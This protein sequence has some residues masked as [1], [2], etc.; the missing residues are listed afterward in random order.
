MLLFAGSVASATVLGAPDLVVLTLTEF[1]EQTRRITRVA[2]VPLLVDADHGYGNALNVMRCVEELETAGVA[3]ITIEDEALPRP[4][5]AGG[6]TAITLDEACGK[7]R[8][9][10]AARTDAA[11]VLLGR[12]ISLRTEGLETCLRRVEA[13]TRTGVDGLYVAGLQ[14]RQEL[15]ALR[16]AT[17]LPMVLGSVPAELQDADFLAEH[18]VRIRLLGHAPFQAAARAAY[19]ALRAQR[20]ETGAG[21]RPRNLMAALTAQDQYD[22][23]VA[24]YLQRD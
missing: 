9:A 16:A 17:S 5:G 21:D 19:D 8:A 13:Y 12:T 10:V 7:L 24:R 18:G 3:G 20:G 1:V 23:D 11:L 6:E 22:R 2:G 4:F 14:R 15:E